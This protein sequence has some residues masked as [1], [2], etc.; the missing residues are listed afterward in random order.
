[1][2]ITE[3]IKNLSTLQIPKPQLDAEPYR[4]IPEEAIEEA[5]F[6]EGERL[7]LLDLRELRANHWEVELAL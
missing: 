7:S 3:D 1:M 6:E 4:K 5:W 2:K